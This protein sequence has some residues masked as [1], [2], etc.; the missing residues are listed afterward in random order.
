MEKLYRTHLI[1]YWPRPALPSLHTKHS[2]RA[3]TWLGLNTTPNQFY[4]F[5]DNQLN[6]ETRKVFWRSPLHPE[7]VFADGLREMEKLRRIVKKDSEKMYK[8]RVV[9]AAEETPIYDVVWAWEPF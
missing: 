5:E 4:K 1:R 7:A 2:S 6:L 9:D 3:T 8:E